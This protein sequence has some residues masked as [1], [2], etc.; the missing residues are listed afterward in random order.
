MTMEGGAWLPQPGCPCSTAVL[1]G[2]GSGSGEVLQVVAR[3]PVPSGLQR[4]GVSHLSRDLLPRHMAPPCLSRSLWPQAPTRM[5]LS[6]WS[7]ALCLLTSG[8][9]LEDSEGSCP[10]RPPGLGVLAPSTRRPHPICMAPR[11]A[12]SVCSAPPLAIWIFRYR[13]EGCGTTSIFSNRPCLASGPEGLHMGYQDQ[14]VRV[15]GG[16]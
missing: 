8:I 7:G 15:P 6:L 9:A 14:W 10:P 5:G 13:P 1:P 3:V 16:S 4:S 12:C 2:C 11:A